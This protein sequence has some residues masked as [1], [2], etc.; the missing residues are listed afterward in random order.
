MH[1]DVFNGDADGIL[2]LHQ[3]RLHTPKPDATLVTGVKRDIKLLDKIKEVKDSNI[4]V[5]DI[6][7][8][9]NRE[10][11]VRLL[12]Q[13]NEV[14][15]TDHHFAGKIPKTDQLT[16]HIDPS[17]IVCTALIID[18][19]LQGKYRSWAVAA[20]Y[21]DNLHDSAQKVAETIALSSEQL[22]RLREL[23]EL[24]NYNGYGANL[25]DLHFTPDAL[26]LALHPYNDPFAFM[27]ESNE[28]A[29]LRRGFKEDMELAMEQK[30]L[31]PD[32]TNRVYTFPN[33]SWSR[34][35][36]GVFSNLRARERKDAAHVL[37]VENDD[38]TLRISVRAPLNNRKDADTLCLSFPTGG[39]RTAAAGINKLPPEML[40]DFLERFQSTYPA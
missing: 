29:T 40:G 28:L 13:G 37:I 3:Y 31:E 24:L 35:V 8:D 11:L 19:L 1:Y 4:A 15:Y 6:S 25:N 33:A 34:R 12:D 7:L 18:R 30:E 23:G 2:A 5:F 38:S 27:E 20:A 39:G 22:A 14:T 21:G 16:V 26:Y 10:N 9:S 32:K 36:A 17:P